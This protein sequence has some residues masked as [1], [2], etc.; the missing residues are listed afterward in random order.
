[1]K[2]NLILFKARFSCKLP[3]DTRFILKHVFRASLEMFSHRHRLNFELPL[4]TLLML[5]RGAENL[6]S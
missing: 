4:W 1:M 2:Q 3:S 6:A 5:Q